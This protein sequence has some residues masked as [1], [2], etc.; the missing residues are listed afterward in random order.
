MV[1]PSAPTEPNESEGVDTEG[2]AVPPYDGR[3]ESADVDG[4][5]SS[6]RDGAEVGGATG[7]VEADDR[8][9]APDPASTPG[10][11]TGSP[12]DEQPASEMPETDLDDDRVGPSHDQ[13]TGRAEDKP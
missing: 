7:P 1:N 2:R 6:T 13:G 8:M 12:A 3:R 11:A 4:P 10:G 5:E 9:R